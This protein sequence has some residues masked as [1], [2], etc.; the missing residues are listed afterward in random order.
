MNGIVHILAVDGSH[1]V[2]EEDYRA[3]EKQLTEVREAW[4]HCREEFT[5]LR[6][7]LAEARAALLE[8]ADTWSDGDCAWLDADG[9]V[10]WAEVSDAMDKHAAAL[11]AA[12]EDRP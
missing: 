12:W 9:Y 8:F 7:Q 2:R 3:L 1:W 6:Q 5:E 4:Q 11:K 10:N